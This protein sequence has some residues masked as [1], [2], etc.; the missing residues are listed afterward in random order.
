[1]Y[2][3]TFINIMHGHGICTQKSTY[4]LFTEFDSIM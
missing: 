3:F 4:Y 2:Y 1:M